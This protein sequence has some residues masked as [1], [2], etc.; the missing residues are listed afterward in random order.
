MM[1]TFT[2]LCLAI[3]LALTM[4]TSAG[5]MVSIGLVQVGGTYSAAV[6]AQAADTL[7]LSLTYGL[8]PGDAVTVLDPGVVWD[9][10][11]ASFDAA[12][13]TR[14]PDSYWGPDP[15][16]AL[17]S[18]VEPPPVPHQVEPGR[19][20]GWGKGSLLAGGITSPCVWGA[21]TSLGTAAFVLSG[22]SGVVAIGAV[23]LPEGTVIGDGTFVDI[24]ASS[25]LGTFTIIP[26][27]AAASLLGLGL[28]GL[29]VAGRCR[30]H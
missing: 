17:G 2:K 19:A 1:R 21:C 26:E 20:S 18:I 13:S 10:A 5:A 30:R 23:G 9:G 7:V 15:P 11:V 6:G 8:Q 3:G 27:P 29:A 12:S 24:A 4:S 22:S 16:R 25:F 28:I 14:T